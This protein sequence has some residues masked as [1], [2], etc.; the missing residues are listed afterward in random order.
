M[1]L[2]ITCTFPIT[3][4]PR[5][6]L[7]ELGYYDNS[8]TIMK[9]DE[10]I[11]SGVITK[12]AVPVTD[13]CK[14]KFVPLQDK[15]LPHLFSDDCV[16]CEL[17]LLPSKKSLALQENPH[18][19]LQKSLF[20]VLCRDIS[21]EKVVNEMINS[22]PRKW[23]RHS[24]MIVFPP[25]SFATNLWQSYFDSLSM[26]QSSQFWSAVSRSLKC[27]RLAVDS[28]VNNDSFRS[29]GS[30]LLLGGD[31]W[32]DH[33]DNGIHYIFDVTKCIFSSG[34]ITEKLRISRFDCEGETVVDLY[35]GIGY[36][37]LPYLVHSKAKLVHACEWNLY[38]IE[39]LKRGLKANGV[40][41]RCIVHFGDC[42]EVSQTFF[43]FFFLYIDIYQSVRLIS[44]IL[45]TE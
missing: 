2:I 43:F 1:S 5:I 41:N 26:S 40:E 31:G 44:R 12:F 16:V 42:K 22:V 11:P 45:L 19:I 33:V 18:I 21:C 6:A 3:S 30:T 32:V 4:F 34:N 20:E 8:R 24:D 39:G 35:A 13:A 17:D 23:E 25:N 36:F 38:A 29:S 37:V 7:E 10:I 15:P 27:E 14:N 9:T 28:K